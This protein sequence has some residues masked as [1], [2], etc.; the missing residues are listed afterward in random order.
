MAVAELLFFNPRYNVYNLQYYDVFQEYIKASAQVKIVKQFGLEKFYLSSAKNSCKYD[1]DRFIA[2]DRESFALR[3][4]M[5]SFSNEEKY[6]ADFL[7]M[8]IGVICKDCGLDIAL[9][10]AKE[11][12]RKTY[13]NTFSCEFCG[14]NEKE[15]LEILNDKNIAR[16]YLTKILPALYGEKDGSHSMLELALNKLLLTCVLGTEEK[17]ARNYITRSFGD[18]TI[19]EDLSDFGSISKIFH[20]YLYS[21]LEFVIEKYQAKIIEKYKKQNKQ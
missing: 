21:G 19:C 10:F 1:S 15:L 11:L 13:S 12:L 9:Q 14:T 4:E 16:D 7:E 8:L 2:P 17:E 3:Q 6:L 5:E 18:R 20:G